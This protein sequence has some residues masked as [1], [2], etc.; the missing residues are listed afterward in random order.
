[1]S[2]RGFGGFGFGV[3]CSEWRAKR[4]PVVCDGGGGWSAADFI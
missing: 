3:L 4:R 2:R 1:M